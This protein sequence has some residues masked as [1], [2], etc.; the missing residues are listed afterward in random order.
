MTQFNSSKN[1]SQSGKNLFGLMF[2][3]ALALHAGVLMIPTGDGGKTSES[4]EKED[5]KSTV[6]PSAS[7][8]A[9]PA[10]S[11]ESSAKE[12]TKKSKVEADSK[13]AEVATDTEKTEAK[14]PVSPSAEADSDEIPEDN[15]KSDATE[16]DDKET[17]ANKTTTESTTSDNTVVKDLRDRIRTKL[18][19]SENSDSV[20]VDKFINNL[21]VAEVAKDNVPYFFEGEALK[22]G[23]RGSVGIAETDVKIA[24]AQ[25]IE[26]ILNKQLGFEIEEISDGYGGEKL[27]KAQDAK[28]VELYLSLVGVGTPNPTQTFVVIWE[29]DPT[30]Q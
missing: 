14:P 16:S 13:K 24:Y 6:E 19:A 1:S 29:K 12:D 9:N 4:A 21:P 27:Y 15:S 2:I 28:G 7:P 22:E 18:L 3:I 8:Q 25:Y 30:I 23:I 5:K 10:K 17:P 26:P 11:P 20:V